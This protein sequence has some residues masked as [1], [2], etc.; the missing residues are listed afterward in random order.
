ML[1]QIPARCRSLPSAGGRLM[2]YL[3]LQIT[4]LSLAPALGR[5]NH[6]S[7][8]LIES[9]AYECETTRSGMIGKSLPLFHIILNPQN[10]TDTIPVIP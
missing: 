8:S 3:G 9:S 7:K 10:A 2:A 4:Y 6:L 5:P 1:E